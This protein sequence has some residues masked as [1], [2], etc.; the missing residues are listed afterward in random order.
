MGRYCQ[1]VVKCGIMCNMKL[2]WHTEKR[3][4]SDLIPAD[5]NPRKLSDKA[6]KLL[7]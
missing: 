1:Q 2:Q 3:L 4:V 5:Y 7:N 6:E